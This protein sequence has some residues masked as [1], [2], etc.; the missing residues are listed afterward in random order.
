MGVEPPAEGWARRNAGWVAIGSLVIGFWMAVLGPGTMPPRP[1][2]GERVGPN[3]GVIGPAAM[4]RVGNDA[5]EEYLRGLDGGRALRTV[6]AARR[7]VVRFV[8]S[9]ESG[10]G[11]GR[12]W[13]RGSGVLVNGG[14]HVLTAGHILEVEETATDLTYSAILT[15]GR[16]LRGRVP[17]VQGGKGGAP[18]GDWGLIELEGAPTAGLPSLDFGSAAEGATVVLLAYSG[19]RGLDARGGVSLVDE[20]TRVPVDHGA[21]LPRR[22]PLRPLAFVGSLVHAE[23]GRADV[24]AGAQTAGGSSGGAVIDLQSRLVGVNKAGWYSAAMV[25][26]EDG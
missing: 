3:G 19:G 6:E 25:T 17:G 24:V 26:A 22:T 16:I 14:R 9:W 21:V 8:V 13:T 11:S 5:A 20:A 2:D 18:N 23:S 7:A 12:S 15:D 4:A 1:V 10:N